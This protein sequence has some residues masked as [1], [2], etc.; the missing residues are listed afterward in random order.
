MGLRELYLAQKQL[1]PEPLWSENEH[2]AET[3]KRKRIWLCSYSC[4]AL[5]VNW[6]FKE[7]FDGKMGTWHV[8]TKKGVAANDLDCLLLLI[9][10][11]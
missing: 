11:I 10:Y 8:K 9:I 6:I 3:K 7:K 2:N 1:P 4:Y 5:K